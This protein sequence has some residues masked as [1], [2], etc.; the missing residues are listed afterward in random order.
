MILSVLLTLWGIFLLFVI[1]LMIYHVNKKSCQTHMFEDW[2]QVDIPYITIDVQGHPFNMI[3]DSGGAVS[4]ITANALKMLDYDESKR[5]INIEGITAEVIPNS[6]VT[7]PFTI[8]GREIKED[9]VVHHTD[10]FANFNKLYGITIHGL[11]GN[12][13]FDK[14]HCKIDYKTHT[15]TFY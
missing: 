13:L 10:D 15:V 8:N 4:M 14:T 9:F 1:L 3:V 7:I 12:E 11:L 5:Q 2:N 6:T